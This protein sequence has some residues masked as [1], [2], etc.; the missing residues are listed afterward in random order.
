MT[1]ED[2]GIS[3]NHESINDLPSIKELRSSVAGFKLLG[4]LL[5]NSE[6]R[7]TTRGISEDIDELVSLVD[8]FY[9]LLGSRNWVFSNALDLERM[10]AVVSMP[11]A[12][13]AERELIEYLKEKGTLHWMISRMNRFPDMRPRMTLLEKAEEDFLAGRYYSSVLVTVSVMDGFMN[14]A[15]KSDGRKGLHARTAE[16]LHSANCVATVWDGL[17]SVQKTFTRSVCA[18]KD[19]PFYEVCRHGIMHGMIIDYDNDVVASKAWCMLF[20]VGDWADSKA[21]EHEKGEEEPQSLLQVLK[22]HSE[23][24]KRIAESSKRLEVWKEHRVELEHPVGPDE[25][26]VRSCVGFL[27]ARKEKNYGVLGSFFPNITNRTSSTQAGEAREY[28]SPHPIEE[29][30]IEEIDRPAAARATARVRFSLSN[31]SWT[32][33]I[34]FSRFNGADSAAEWEPGEWKVLGYGADPFVASEE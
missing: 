4:W 5:W 29:Y 23:V 33:S 16:E 20:G 31:E 25:E 9:R 6:I 34:R 7:E 10:R 32:V 19:E 15:S 24:Q 8:D 14:D 18:R 26:I 30:K 12:E 17:P 11:T 21:K 1:D 27:E 22:D 28:Y 2:Y 3:G 13:D